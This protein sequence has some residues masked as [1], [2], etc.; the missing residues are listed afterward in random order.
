MVEVIALEVIIMADTVA[1]GKMVIALLR[2]TCNKAGFM[3]EQPKEAMILVAI[4]VSPMFGMRTLRLKLTKLN[5][6]IRHVVLLTRT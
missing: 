4:I 5:A 2:Q 1:S 6:K 3:T